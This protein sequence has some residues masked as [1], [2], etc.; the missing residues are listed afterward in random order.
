MELQIG[1][2]VKWQLE[3]KECV[4]CYLEDIDEDT[5]AVVTHTVGGRIWNQNVEVDKS[6]LEKY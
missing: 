3:G 5:A 1:D 4:G 6:K 2:K